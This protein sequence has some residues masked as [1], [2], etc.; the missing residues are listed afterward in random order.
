[1]SV[2]IFFALL[3][4]FCLSQSLKSSNE[5]RSKIMNLPSSEVCYENVASLKKAYS[6]L[7]C[8][9]MEFDLD[10]QLYA[11]CL[12]TLPAYGSSSHVVRGWVAASDGTMSKMFVDFRARELGAGKLEFS[13]INMQLSL[14]GTANNKFKDVAVLQLVLR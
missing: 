3:P 7:S 13:R 8:E 4:A 9:W 2:A 10:G 5:T 6:E 12:I 11:A 1:M 14:K